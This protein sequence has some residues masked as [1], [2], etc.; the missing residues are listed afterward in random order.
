LSGAPRPVS[1]HSDSHAVATG[2][3]IQPFEI[4]VDV[5]PTLHGPALVAATLLA[6]TSKR[7]R[8]LTLIVLSFAAFKLGAACTLR[9]IVVI[10][11]RSI[12][13]LNPSGLLVRALT[14]RVDG[15][16]PTECEFTAI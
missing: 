6:T 3:H 9:H 12:V 16:R 8:L 10:L 5:L 15:I 1:R 4:P 11:G 13:G 2:P 7:L 14:V